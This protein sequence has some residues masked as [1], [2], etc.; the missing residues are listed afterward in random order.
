M[1]NMREIASNAL[2]IGGILTMGGSTV[3][4]LKS[5][6]TNRQYAQIQ[7]IDEDLRKQYGVTENCVTV[8]LFSGSPSEN[9][10]DRVYEATTV[11]QE[12][13]ILA[14]YHQELATRSKKIPR[15]FAAERR[16]IRDIIGLFA[17]VGIGISSN[18]LEKKKR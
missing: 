1:K 12:R 13:I 16:S 14:N 18:L 7:T 9:C 2:M 10:S 11:D 5:I 3:D 4:L 15:D 6:A 17:G 8:G